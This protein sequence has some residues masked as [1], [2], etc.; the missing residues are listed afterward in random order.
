MESGAESEEQDEDEN[1]SG[2]DAAV[3]FDD[4]VEGDIGARL[5]LLSKRANVSTMHLAQRNNLFQFIGAVHGLAIPVTMDCGSSENF[6]SGVL[7][8]ILGLKVH[9]TPHSIPCG[10]GHE[11]GQLLKPSNNAR[12][13]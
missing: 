2:D 4:E 6:I 13:H 7:A 3:E 11:S 12:F 5:F 10:V 1:E 9:T 8:R